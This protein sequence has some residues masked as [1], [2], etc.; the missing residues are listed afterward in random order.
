VT[1]LADVNCP[2][3]QEDVV[4]NWKPPYSLVEDAVSGAETEAAPCLLYL[5][6]ACLSASGKEGPYMA[7]T[8]SPLVFTLLFCEHA[9]GLWGALGPFAGNFFFFFSCLSDH[10]TVWV[11][12]SH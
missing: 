7:G 11:A 3:S 2:G 12:I 1:L 10:P 9:K 6:H 8:C 5:L 4:S